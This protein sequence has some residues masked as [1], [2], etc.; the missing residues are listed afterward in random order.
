MRKSPLWRPQPDDGLGPSASSGHLSGVFPQMSFPVLAVLGLI[1]AAGVGTVAVI[2]FQSADTALPVESAIRTGA[3]PASPAKPSTAEKAAAL[4]PVRASPPI[5]ETIDV[6]IAQSEFDV[7]RLE[8]LTGM[9]GATPSPPA[10]AVSRDASAMVSPVAVTSELRPGVEAAPVV[11]PAATDDDAQTASIQP[12]ATKPEDTSTLVPDPQPETALPALPALSAVKVNR[13]VN[14][15]SGPA[16]EASV[17]TVV[18]SGATVQAQAD[19]QWCV[20]T[21]NGQRGYIY[22]SFLGGNR[23]SSGGSGGLSGP[24]LY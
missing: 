15:R 24:G 23:T 4:A 9:V 17:V 6:A 3:T 10:P 8:E 14:M 7:A 19:C 11:A 13:H 18:P 12:P 20:V 16:D 22:K 21:Y 2:S 1:L 5:P